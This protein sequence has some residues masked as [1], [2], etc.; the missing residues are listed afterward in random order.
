MK[1]IDCKHVIQL[2]TI[3]DK[4]WCKAPAGRYHDNQALS[5][6]PFLERKCKLFELKEVIKNKNN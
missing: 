3:H 1:C 6:S 5:V 2:D 4:A